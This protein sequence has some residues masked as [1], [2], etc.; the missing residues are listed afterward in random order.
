[1]RPAPVVTR[2]AQALVHAG[3]GVGA[4]VLRAHDRPGTLVLVDAALV[5]RDG[6]PAPT[7]AHLRHVDAPTDLAGVRALTEV[8]R[9][10]DVVV[11][12][13]GGN[14]MDLAV[15]GA[16]AAGDP[17]VLDDLA[18]QQGRA[19]FVVPRVVPGTRPRLVMVPSTLGTG[20]ESSAVAC[21]AAELA[22]GPAKVLVSLPDVRPDVVGYDPLLLAGPPW[23]VREGAFE[24]A[25]RVLAAAAESASTLR[26][27]DLDAE[28]VLVTV[29]G[30]VDTLLAQDGP[31]GPDGLDGP[32]EGTLLSLATLSADSHGGWSLRGRGTAPSS[33]WFLAAELSTA[34]GL[35][36][37]Q[38][39][40]VLL[41]VWLRELAASGRADA[42]DGLCRALGVPDGW[43]GADAWAQALVPRPLVR[44]DVAAVADRVV[45]RFGGGRPMRRE[46]R[47]EVVRR[48]LTDATA[49]V[50]VAPCSTTR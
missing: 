33:L 21:Y 7:R 47:P 13:G 27:A 10:C 8:V 26:R 42:V 40:R 15:L 12:V 20:A 31:D 17:R 32:D 36:K 37:A 35:R 4:A 34:T 24:V 49:P 5:G 1:M 3:R 30:L 6:L 46:V 25:T 19:G 41:P 29:G 45:R 14:T 48:V 44:A 50:E 16:V 2:P 23:L 28:H 22:D 9:G 18:A 38:S 11:A 39:M 43:R